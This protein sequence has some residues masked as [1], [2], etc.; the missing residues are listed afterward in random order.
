MDF[1]ICVSRGCISYPGITCRSLSGSH[2]PQNRDKM[3]G[4]DPGE[5]VKGLFAP[6]G[7][8]AARHSSFPETA[9]QSRDPLSPPAPVVPPPESPGS[10]AAHRR[11]A[12]PQQCNQ[13]R[14]HGSSRQEGHGL[15]PYSPRAGSPLPRL[16]AP[17]GRC[18]RENRHRLQSPFP[19]A[20]RL[21]TR[22]S[23]SPAPR[24]RRG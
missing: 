19:P 15:S 1:R 6:P 14:G 9:N 11:P 4:T 7:D 12:S 22:D 23:R 2:L 20:G 21:S 10:Y 24:C 8:E 5:E 13:A 18:C 17:H 16:T 3:A